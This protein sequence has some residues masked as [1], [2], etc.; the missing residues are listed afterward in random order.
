M[1]TMLQSDDVPAKIVNLKGLP[2]KIL[3]DDGKQFYLLFCMRINLASVFG[4]WT[5]RFRVKYREKVMAV[6]VQTSEHRKNV[7]WKSD[8]TLHQISITPEDQR[9]SGGIFYIQQSQQLFQIPKIYPRSENLLI[10]D[11]K[12]S[13]RPKIIFRS[14]TSACPR[15]PKRLSRDRACSTWFQLLS[16]SP[17][18]KKV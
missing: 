18:M 6:A 3:W 10:Q 4:S 17:W 8:G 1:L 16:P 7:I 12:I 5:G 2:A 13:L 15:F 11:A 9:E 14:D